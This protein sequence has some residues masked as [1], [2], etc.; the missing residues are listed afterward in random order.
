[1]R[2]SI[3][4]ALIVLG[5][6][7]SR[8]QVFEREP[9]NSI[10]QANTIFSGVPISAQL[11]SET[12][13]DTFAISVSAPGALNISLAKGFSG[14]YSIS[15]LG[16]S[17]N[18]L[19]A[20]TTGSQSFS[21]LTGAASAGTYYIR[22]A[23]VSFGFAS[24]FTN[25]QYG[26][27]VTYVTIG[28]TISVQ[29]EDQN[30]TEGSSAVFS[31][32]AVGVPP[33]TYQWR[34]NG[35]VIASATSSRVRFPTLVSDNTGIIS[36]TIT[37]STGTVTSR[38]AQLTVTRPNPPRLINLSVLTSVPTNDSTT[39]GFVISGD[40]SRT[41]VI[42]AIGPTLASF[43]VSN[44]IPDPVLTVF[45]S[46]R[47]TIARNDNWLPGDAAA[48]SGVGAFALPSS[49]RDAVVVV[50]LSPGNYT[51]QVTGV[52]GAG[53]TALIEVYEAR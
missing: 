44:T 14:D 50:T 32:I 19:A 9:N 48:M 13:V 43:G 26:V 2:Y 10:A 20:Y 29:P 15:L 37:N 21:V 52:G 35:Q 30:V 12:D 23:T 45:N 5:I 36:V 1:M 11:L 16:S 33:L 34:W 46:A 51:A 38:G 18:V 24:G 49:S 4:I 31:V 53:G 47:A 42:R 3:A 17:G 41:V 8:A 28:P 25:A 7:P 40:G 22:V 27:T 39:A 6:S